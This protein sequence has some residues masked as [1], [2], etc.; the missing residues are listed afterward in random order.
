MGMPRSE[1]LTKELQQLLNQLELWIRK[2]YDDELSLISF[3]IDEKS[4]H[5]NI[6]VYQT[7]L[8]LFDKIQQN[9][10]YSQQEREMLNLLRT[11]WISELKN[12]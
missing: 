3:G 6:S 5:T 7:L 1:I 10:Y 8:S 12:K 2:K 11:E 9:G 4:I